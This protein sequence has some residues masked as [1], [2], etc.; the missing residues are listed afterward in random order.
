MSTPLLHCLLFSV[1][2]ISDLLHITV[3][4]CIDDYYRSS[5]Q[6]RLKAACLVIITYFV[7]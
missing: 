7:L 5:K 2:I 3:Y 6:C 1:M 4:E